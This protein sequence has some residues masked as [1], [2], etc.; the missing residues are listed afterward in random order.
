[1]GREEGKTII[2]PQFFAKFKK[3]TVPIILKLK[4]YNEYYLA[5]LKT[6]SPTLFSLVLHHW[7]MTNIE[8]F[9]EIVLGS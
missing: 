6:C 3:K 1:M 5:V 7:I 9:M 8:P 2:P 4:K